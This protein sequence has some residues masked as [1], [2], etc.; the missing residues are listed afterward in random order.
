MQGGN[1]KPVRIDTAV[2]KDYIAIIQEPTTN[3]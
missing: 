2:G 1:L 3:D